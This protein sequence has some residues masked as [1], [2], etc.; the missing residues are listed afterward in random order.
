MA[1]IRTGSHWLKHFLPV[2]QLVTLCWE[3]VTA[4]GGG[5]HLSEV[6]QSCGGMLYLPTSGLALCFLTLTTA[7]VAISVNGRILPLSNQGPRQSS[8]LQR[9]DLLILITGT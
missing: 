5:P 4:L 1:W 7:T 8:P 6:R 3:A 2:P 9:G